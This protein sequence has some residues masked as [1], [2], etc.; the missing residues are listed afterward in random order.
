MSDAAAVLTY[1]FGDE[2]DPIDGVAALE[3]RGAKWFY[4]GPEVDREIAARF[5]GDLERARR[6]ELD[7]WATDARDRLALIVL[8][9]QF[10]R[11]V[12]RGT[13]LAFAQDP[14]AQRLAVS[15]LEASMDQSLALHERMFFSLPLSHAEDRI[16]QERGLAYAER[17]TN[18]APAAV[19]PFY[20]RGLE[21]TRK[22]HD[23][24]VRFGRFPTRNATLGRASTPEE[25]TYLEELKITGAFI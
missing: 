23:V 21:M 2:R 10:S 15:G 20:E 9:D 11:N 18:E 16:L 4:G 7:D 17:V 24:V 19:R 1:W 8:L 25:I 3:R 14:A 6:G 13:P 12:F 22:H 5:G